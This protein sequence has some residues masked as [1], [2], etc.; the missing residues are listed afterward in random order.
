MRVDNEEDLSIEKKMTLLNQT[1]Q[2]S[3]KFISRVKSSEFEKSKH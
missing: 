1:K 3:W 2:N